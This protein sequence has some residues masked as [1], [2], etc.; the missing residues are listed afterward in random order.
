MQ[1]FNKLLFFSAALHLLLLLVLSHQFHQTPLP[2]IK[3]K[4]KVKPIQATLY[5]PLVKKQLPVEV[6]KV[7][8]IQE[9]IK[10]STAKVKAA[11]TIKKVTIK[12]P[13]KNKTNN[14]LSKQS[15]TKKAASSDLSTNSISQD[16]LEKLHQRLS[17]QARDNSNNDSYNQYIKDKNTIDP[18]ITKFNQL[19]EA[20]AETREVNCNANA[21]NIAVVVASNLLGGSTHCNR[22]PNLKRFLKKRA[23]ERP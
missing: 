23:K 20:K 16:A 10:P 2:R 15:V 14:I 12:T 9:T 18:S 13:L 11:K 3:E 8:P 1:K 7:T 19:P 5:F 17:K 21:F 22:M 4:T 6:E